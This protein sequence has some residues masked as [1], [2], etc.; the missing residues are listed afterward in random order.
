[1][2]EYTKAYQCAMDYDDNDDEQIFTAKRMVLADIKE[3]GDMEFLEQSASDIAASF[4]KV[5]VD[6][7]HDQLTEILDIRDA[8]SQLDELGVG[9]DQER[10]DLEKVVRACHNNFTMGMAVL[11]YYLQI[12]E[13]IKEEHEF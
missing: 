5:C 7:S 2:S 8:E 12:F 10:V 9:D 1:M 13:S 4:M 11:S 3:M 6:T